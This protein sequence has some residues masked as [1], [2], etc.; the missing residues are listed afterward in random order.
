MKDL[1]ERAGVSVN[2]VER[3]ENGRTIP[4]PATLKVIRQAFE[5]AGVRFT[6]QGGV[7][8]PK[9]GGAAPPEKEEKP[10]RQLHNILAL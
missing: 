3:F 8:P 4:M 9:K 1:A 7:E 2:T 5:E 10:W 6:D